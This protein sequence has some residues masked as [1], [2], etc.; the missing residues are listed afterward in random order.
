MVSVYLLY[1]FV[2]KHIQPKACIFVHQN[3]TKN[4]M[5]AHKN[6]WDNKYGVVLKSS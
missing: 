3:T 2:E 4:K 1:I 6:H 5:S